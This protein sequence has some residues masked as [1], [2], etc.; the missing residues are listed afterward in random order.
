MEFTDYIFTLLNNETELAV[1][2][3][4]FL[5]FYYFAFYRKLSFNI[6]D[7]FTI[8]LIS[9]AGAA[10][11]VYVMFVYG[12]P[13]KKYLFSFVTCEI[14]LFAAIFLIRH[15]ANK[16]TTVNASIG[17]GIAV[18]KTQEGYLRIFFTIVFSSYIL[19]QFI[20][21][22]LVGLILF[23][24]DE[25]ITHVN[26]YNN[27]G[28]L[29]LLLYT[30][31]PIFTVC[32]FIKRKIFKKLSLFD[33]FC[34]LIAL[35][36]MFMSGS[37]SSFAIFFAAF[38]VVE[39][40]F[41]KLENKPK[42]KIPV[43][44]LALFFLS[45][46]LILT[47]GTIPS[48]AEDSPLAKLFQRIAVSGDGFIIGYD[49]SAIRYVLNGPRKTAFGYILYPFYGTVARLLGSPD[50]PS[51]VGMD[52]YEYAFGVN[53]AGANGRHNLLSVIFWGPYWGWMLSFIIGTFLGY[54][55]FYLFEKAVCKNA[56]Y[57]VFICIVTTLVPACITDAFLFSS[58]LYMFCAIFV[59]FLIITVI[60]YEVI[61]IAKALLYNYFLTHAI[62]NN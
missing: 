48:Y 16:S 39:Y 15:F 44:F 33:Y 52:L 18:T 35:F 3:L 22:K 45:I 36:S 25:G 23:S 60:A 27:Y 57:F 53:D 40:K 41:A 49:D 6:F 34:I 37:K 46:I 59:A 20:A 61:N 24:T 47:I 50:R 30:M 62:K 9:N 51:V 43:T 55:R 4:L 17:S 38:A 32:M 12:S 58:M 56:F 1:I 10:L 7:A 13:D 42:K 11:G 19:L 5:A 29:F 54:V 14:A 2:F 21:I 26:A 28:A 8:E 31:N